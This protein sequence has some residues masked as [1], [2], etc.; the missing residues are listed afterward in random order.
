MEG[1]EGLRVKEEPVVL[2]DEDELFGGGKFGSID[3]LGGG[4][5]PFMVPKPIEGLRDAGPP[6][7]LKK[8]YEI[9][10]DPTTDPVISWTACCTSFVV[11][12]PHKF[13]ADLLPKNF[14]HSNFSS[15]VRQLNTYF[16]VSLKRF[17]KIDPDRWEFANERFQKGKKHML[18]EIKRRKQQHSP[19]KQEE[20]HPQ[21]DFGG[22][23]VEKLRSDQLAMK[24]EILKLK[25]HQENMKNRFDAVKKRLQTAEYRQR[26]LVIF[27][28]R[29]FAN[30]LFFDRIVQRQKKE[31]DCGE[32][33]KR[34]RLVAPRGNLSSAEARDSF[35]NNQA[36]EELATIESEIQTLFSND[37]S[38]SP[39]HDRNANVNSGTSTPDYNFENFILWEKLMEDEMIFEN[40]AARDLAKHQSKMVLQ[41]EELIANPPD[42]EL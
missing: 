7:F 12:D 1:V 30:P 24:S 10:D 28:A 16:D 36:Q 11:W 5:S 27:I 20:A 29:V 17:K 25:Q 31:L 3:P 35:G 2:L 23:E 42:W 38:T 8:T 6:P 14:K 4:A 39:V 15:F 22:T 40:E 32:M 19:M 18:K 33:S 21:L 34:R 26:Q 41:L 37:E 9:V 13:S